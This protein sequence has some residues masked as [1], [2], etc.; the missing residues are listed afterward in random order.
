LVW[1]GNTTYPSLDDALQA[2]EDALARL[3]RD[4]TVPRDRTATV[5]V[6]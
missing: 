1:E 3:L 5:F 6:E 4:A 2:F